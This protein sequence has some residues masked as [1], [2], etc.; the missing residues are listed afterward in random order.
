MPLAVGS[1]FL[2][3]Q[4]ATGI[5]GLRERVGEIEQPKNAWIEIARQAGSEIEKFLTSAFICKVATVFF[6]GN[7]DYTFDSFD[8]TFA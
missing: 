4:V 2:F 6:F 1:M 5:D 3:T 7:I 8:Y